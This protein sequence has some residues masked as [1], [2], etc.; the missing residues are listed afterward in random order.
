[1]P[2]PVRYAFDDVPGPTEFREV[3]PGIHWLRM[4]LPFVLNHINLWLLEDDSGWTIVDTGL[5]SPEVKELWEEVFARRLGGRPVRRIVVTHFHPDH[6]GLAGWIAGRFGVE[7]WCT[8]GEWAFGRMLSLDDGSSSVASFRRF[9]RAAGFDEDLLRV[10]EERKN[11]YPSRVHPLPVAFRRLRDGEELAIGG[12]TWKVIVGTG[13]SPEHACLW[14]EESGVLISGDQI[15]PKI[16]PNVSVWPQEPEADPLGLF[17]ANLERF[18]PLPG[19][20]L[21]LPSHNAPFTGLPGRL[22]QLAHHHDARLE[23][24]ADACARPC[25]GVDILKRLFQRQLDVHQLFFAI[26]ESLAHLHYLMG[27]GR[28]IRRQRADGVHLFEKA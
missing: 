19:T 11:P 28:I 4:P 23:E 2:H 25:T 14:C 1:M 12:R 24:T 5:A 15:L 9:Y 16:S 6:M 27:Q 20:T 21:V 17:L 13:H 22:D 8:L 3:A 26:G 7:T 18:R 10:V